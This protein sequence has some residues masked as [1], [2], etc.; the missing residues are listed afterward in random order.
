MLRNAAVSGI[1]TCR[2]KPVTGLGSTNGGAQKYY[3][4][5]T[6]N[7][8]QG[9]Q[10]RPRRWD[11]SLLYGAFFVWV[12]ISLVFAVRIFLV[13][14][15]TVTPKANGDTNINPQSLTAPPGERRDL[16]C[17]FMCRWLL[18]AL[19]KLRYISLHRTAPCDP[20][21]IPLRSIH[22]RPFHAG[23]SRQVSE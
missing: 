18:A 11:A 9:R 21:T 19:V 23:C 15:P 7:L 1:P 12:T 4:D 3:N 14:G 16:T 6:M 13:K 10:R 8:Q 22:C 5:C 20:F 2:A 17:L